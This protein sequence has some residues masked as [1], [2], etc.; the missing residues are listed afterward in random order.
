MSMLHMWPT[1]RRTRTRC[2]HFS[3]RN[4]NDGAVAH[5]RLQPCGEHG[6][7]LS[8]QAPQQ[9]LAVKTGTGHCFRYDPRRAQEARIRCRWIAG[10]S[11]PTREFIQNEPRFA[12]YCAKWMMAEEKCR[13]STRTNC[14]SASHL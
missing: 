1:V 10:P 5:H 3:R 8:K 6:Y 11:V 9:E 12:A 2:G 13:R 14:R 4:P 7:D